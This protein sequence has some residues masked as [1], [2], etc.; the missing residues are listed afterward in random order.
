V[1]G[2]LQ[3]IRQQYELLEEKEQRE[4]EADNPES[5]AWE[6]DEDTFKDR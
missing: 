4:L 1:D 6:P 3:V 2:Y 5:L